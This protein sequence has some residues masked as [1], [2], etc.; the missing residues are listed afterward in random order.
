MHADIPRVTNSEGGS[1]SAHTNTSPHTHIHKKQS[2][3]SFC[4]FFSFVIF[5]FS[6]YIRCV[7]F[8]MENYLVLLFHL[9][10]FIA[11]YRTTEAL[12]EECSFGIQVSYN[13]GKLDSGYLKMGKHQLIQCCA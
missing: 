13:C 3:Y 12:L 10:V 11:F 8:G 4:V 1:G 7:V 2:K 9:R 5:S 6:V